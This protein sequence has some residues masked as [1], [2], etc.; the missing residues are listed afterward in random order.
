MKRCLKYHSVQGKY[1][2]VRRCAQFAGGDLGGSLP[3]VW[4]GVGTPGGWLD[5]ILGPAVGGGTTLG[6]SLLTKAFT[7]PGSK[8]GEY[9]GL[10]GAGAG[11]AISVPVGFLR[12]W[13]TAVAGM[14]TAAL[15]GATV[16]LA[17]VVGP[18][19][20]DVAGMG[21]IVPSEVGLITPEE[22]SGMG[23]ITPEEVAGLGGGQVSIYEGHGVGDTGEAVDVLQDGVNLA[24]FGTNPVQ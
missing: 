9:A 6:V 13:Q 20:S 18:K 7:G 22:V 21:L 23:L 19:A 5:S 10:I 17:G 12:G 2:P 4:E 24:A 14:L 8:V 15:A 3:T 1:G 11:I 16:W